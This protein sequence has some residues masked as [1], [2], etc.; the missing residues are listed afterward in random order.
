MPSFIEIYLE[1]FEL[2]CTHTN[3][4]KLFFHYAGDLKTPKN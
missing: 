3:S 4:L 2:S 1:L